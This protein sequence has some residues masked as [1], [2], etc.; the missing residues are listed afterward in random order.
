MD[1]LNKLTTRVL[2]SAFIVYR[3]S[4]PDLL[5]S[6][7]QIV[8]EV[9]SMEAGIPYHSHYEIPLKHKERNLPTAY[10]LDFLF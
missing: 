10:R 5:E 2:D 6:A 7:Y 1:D 3:N 4:G 8:L 9:E